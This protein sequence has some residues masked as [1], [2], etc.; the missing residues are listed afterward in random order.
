MRNKNLKTALALALLSVGLG[1]HGQTSP[2]RPA[3]QYPEPSA[4]Q[5]GAASV[6]M[7]DSAVFATPYIGLAVGR[8][9]NLFLSRNNPKSSNLYVTSPG[10]KLDAPGPGL[11][12]QSRFQA[13]PG[14]YSSIPDDPY[15]DF[16][17]NNHPPPP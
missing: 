2:I 11:V 6:Q 9:D 17:P 15:P 5:S 7:G 3:Y 12:L 10:I 14:P 16:P 13:H 1:A 4:S 8:D